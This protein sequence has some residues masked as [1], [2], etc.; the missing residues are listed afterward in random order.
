[1]D[2]ELQILK[3]LK[4][5]PNPTVSIIDQYCCAYNDLFP[6]VRSYECF[7]YLHQGII[8]PIK[9]KS[10]P[11]IAK[12][13]GISSAQSLHH[14]LANSPWSVEELKVKR[15]TITLEAFKNQKITVVID[16]TGDR[17]KG[18]KTD[19]VA[20]QYLGSVG[21]VDRGI[22]SVNAYGVYRNIT[23]PLMFKIFKPKGTLKNGDTYKT[24]IEL[25]SEIVNEL[26]EFGFKIE[27]VLADSLYGEASMFIETLDKYK[28]DWVLAI[29]SNHGVLMPSSQRVRAN[30]WA[31]FERIFSN[32]KSE[33]RYIRE[34][35][36]GKRR[37][38][39]YWEITTEPETMPE[40]S[41][42]FV[43]TN[44]QATRSQMKKILGNLYGLRTWVEYGFRQCKQELGWTDYRFTNFNNINKW[45][46]II[47]CAYLMISLNTETLGSLNSNNLPQSQVSNTNTEYKSHPQWNSPTG[48]KNVLNNVRLLVQPSLLLWLIVPWLEV[49]P[50]SYLLLGLHHLIDSIN[51]LPQLSLSG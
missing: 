3:H 5:T 48:W 2:V 7:K 10:L 49:F 20:R 45:W 37:T 27:L 25:A 11:E 32:Q 14:F 12:V 1:M 40:N 28:L 17:K 6:E 50:N 21:K 38:R 35:I 46:E 19:Y 30:K 29:R 36:F 15:L 31:K 22:V 42:S 34:I 26:I 13:V 23:F 39:T 16:E 8:S 41:T 33:I 47:F 9:R 43:M 51:Q 4:R 24:K 44:I 18:S